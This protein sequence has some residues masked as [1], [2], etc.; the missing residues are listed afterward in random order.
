MSLHRSSL[1]NRAMMITT[2]SGLFALTVTAAIWLF[3]VP[4]DRLRE[5]TKTAQL[6]AN[7]T[8]ADLYLE[9][10]VG[11]WENVG[12][13]LDRISTLTDI[14]YV[15]LRTPLQNIRRASPRPDCQ[16]MGCRLITA[17]APVHD[18]AQPDA[19]TLG[20]IVVAMTDESLLRQDRE[21]VATI[22][23]VGLLLLLLVALTGRVMATWAVRPID[24]LQRATRR[25][26]AGDLGARVGQ[27]GVEE[28][29]ALGQDFNQMAAS[30]QSQI[31]A[32]VRAETERNAAL[33]ASRLKTEFLATMSHEIRT[34]MHGVIGMTT[35]LL[36]SDLPSDQREALQTIQVC[37]NQL[38][39]II[40]DILDFSK[41][42][43]GRMELEEATFSPRDLVDE[44][45]EMNAEAAERKG[46]ELYCVE[47]GSCDVSVVGDPTRFRQILLNLIGNALKFT[48]GGHVKVIL[49]TEL[50]SPQQA[51]LTVAVEDT[52][53][54]IPAHA[55]QQI[56]EA[57]RQVDAST[58]R[59]FGGTGLGL[60]ITQRLIKLMG[61]QLIVESQENKGSTFRYRLTLPAVV[62][63]EAPEKKKMTLL[64]W[65][66]GGR[67][68]ALVRDLRR[69]V[70]DVERVASLGELERRS[71][72]SAA[73]WDMVLV[74]ID[75]ADPSRLPN[76]SIWASSYRV[77]VQSRLADGRG[78]HLP[79]RFRRLERLM[80]SSEQISA[81]LSRLEPPKKPSSDLPAPRFMILLAED[82]E[83]NQKVARRMLARLA[84]HVDSALDGKEALAA[85]MANDYDAIL[86]DCQMPEMDGFE[87]TR[88]IR[89]SEI[90]RRVPIIALTA[91]ASEGDRRACLAS[92]MDDYL[93][94]P[95]SYHTLELTLKRW[96]E[97]KGPDDEI[98]NPEQSS[99]AGVR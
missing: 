39:G 11:D 20:K 73:A 44:V 29:D 47:G 60:A 66:A 93:A 78:L 42:E 48:S 25:L 46:L 50:I 4:Q 77:R 86:M 41:I 33:Q 51:T 80:A 57:F 99:T 89:A 21:R 12:G 34:P 18:N 23:P 64:V 65:A 28:L 8:A 76:N 68:D 90:D 72:D 10:A 63:G 31:A 49:D 81:S 3:W 35:L 19:P 58:T 85:A 92:G 75:H 91:G 9:V 67:G 62:D 70:Q 15:E 53:I 52:G 45:L 97:K 26:S 2:S 79:T 74:D 71:R 40:N 54:G 1:L 59:R 56:F 6:L 36:D 82:N 87:A 83:V 17:E 94:K 95:V 32:R 27:L 98:I 14:A 55:R 5:Q 7:G 38:L 30:V 84:C 61:G 37:S 24:A 69:C 88:R 22:I 43:A 16:T 13:K 96:I